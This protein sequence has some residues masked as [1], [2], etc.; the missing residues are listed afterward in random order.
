VKHITTEIEDDIHRV[1][2]TAASNDGATLKEYAAKVLTDHAKNLK[3]IV[4][5]QEEK[6]KKK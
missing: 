2:R 3:V 4:V 1:L 5:E 6:N